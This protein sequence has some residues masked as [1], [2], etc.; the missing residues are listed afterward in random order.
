MKKYEN[1]YT[2]LLKM[3]I[4]TVRIN[5]KIYFFLSG[6]EVALTCGRFKDYQSSFSTLV[7]EWRS[8]VMNRCWWL[9]RNVIGVS[10]SFQKIIK[11]IT[12][13]DEARIG[14]N[15][16]HGQGGN[17][18]QETGQD[19]EQGRGAISSGLMIFWKLLETPITF[20]SNHQHQHR[21]IMEDRHSTTSVEKEDW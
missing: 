3:F 15:E 14:D 6:L 2:W 10:R 11:H 7:V 19:D 20:L 21:F 17:R 4:K 1:R 5:W 9:L 18:A 13:W 12:G 8:S 16:A